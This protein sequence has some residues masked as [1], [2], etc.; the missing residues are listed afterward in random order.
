ML[1]SKEVHPLQNRFQ[2]P[3]FHSV[4]YDGFFASSSEGLRD[5]T[6]TEHLLHVDFVWEVDL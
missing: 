5:H 2:C 3:T 4:V 1:Q 6:Y